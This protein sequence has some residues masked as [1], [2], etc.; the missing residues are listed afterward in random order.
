MPSY[1]KKAGSPSVPPWLRRGRRQSSV[2]RERQ[3]VENNFVGPT[4]KDSIYTPPRPHPRHHTSLSQNGHLTQATPC[5]S[6]QRPLETLP[7][8]TYLSQEGNL[9]PKSLVT[10]SRACWRWCPYS[11]KSES[12]TGWSLKSLVFPTSQHCVWASDPTAR[13]SV[14]RDVLP[15]SQANSKSIPRTHANILVKFERAVRHLW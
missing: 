10:T 2:Q 12:Q 8:T 13:P 11:W 7:L 6:Y 1:Q 4:K 15:E 3:K 9:C 14:G 5:S